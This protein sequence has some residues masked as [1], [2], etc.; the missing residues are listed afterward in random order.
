MLLRI[1]RWMR[2]YVRFTV[3]GRFPERFVNIT[4]R[5][6]IRLWDVERRDGSL[7]AAMYMADYRRIRSAARSC[8]VRL[9]ITGKYGLPTRMRRYRARGGVA[10]GA[11]VFLMTVFVMSQFIWCVDVTGLDTISECAMRALLREHGLYVGACKIGMDY[12]GVSRAVMLDDRRVGWMAVNVTGS[13]ASVEVKES[14][15]APEVTDIDA[16]CNVKASRDGVIKRIDAGE[17]DILLKEG[18]GVVGGQLVVS[19]VMEDALGGVR[20]VHA[21]AR[22]LASVQ[23]SVSFTIPETVTVLRPDSETGERLSLNLFGLRIP[24]IFS[25]VRS[26]YAVGNRHPE[27][28]APLGVALPVGV[29]RERV[30][31][32]SSQRITFNN[33]SVEELLEKRAQL[34]EVFSVP[35]TVTERRSRLTHRDGVYTLTVD[36]V[37]EQDIAVQTPIGTENAE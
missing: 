24:F 13:Y 28:P 9:R 21:E 27:S 7:S 22:I 20:L 6:G 10:V 29:I 2:G 25:S 26:E 4:A 16:P 1:L 23:D 19:G 8:D 33:N 3:C 37:S 14:S 36:Y 35:G 12:P 15:S 32:L 30:Q 31:G 5:R 17:G 34:Y 18:S 11:F